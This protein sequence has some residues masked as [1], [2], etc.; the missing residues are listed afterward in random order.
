VEVD[1]LNATVAAY[2]LT[3][4]DLHFDLGRTLYSGSLFFRNE[5][6]LVN[7]RGYSA[8]GAIWIRS[9]DYDDPY[10]FGH[11]MV[12]TLQNERGSAIA[13]WHYKGLRFNFLAFAPGVPALLEGWPDHDQRLHEREATLYAGHP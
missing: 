13:D 5:N 3:A 8:P 12:H 7:Q 4:D 10:V 2:F 6:A 9:L 1:V 11:E